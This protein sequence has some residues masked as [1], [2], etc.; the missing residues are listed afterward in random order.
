MFQGVRTDGDGNQDQAQII[1]GLEAELTRKE[2]EIS[3]LTL[4]LS[5][6]EDKNTLEVQQLNR[7]LTCQFFYCIKTNGV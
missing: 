7:Q 3:Q 2:R 1:T 6:S 4:D 5:A